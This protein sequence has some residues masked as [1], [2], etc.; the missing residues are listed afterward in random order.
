MPYQDGQCT[1]SLNIL[2]NQHWYEF[3]ILLE[4]DSVTNLY[5]RA[6]DEVT[7]A[8]IHTHG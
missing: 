7:L 5:T 6:I 8:C 1:R 3:Y 4:I 2:C